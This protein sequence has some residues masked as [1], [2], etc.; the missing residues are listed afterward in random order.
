[1]FKFCRALI[2]ASLLFL[3][4]CASQKEVAEPRKYIEPR[5]TDEKP[6]ELLVNKVDIE[7]EFS[8]T[9]TKPYVEHLFPVSLERA[10]RVWATDRLKAVDYGASRTAKFIIKDASVTEQVEKSPDI[11]Q[12]DRLKYHAS[13]SVILK[14]IDQNGSMAQTSIDAWRELGIPADTSI[15]QKEKYWFEMIE[16]LMTDFDA[17]IEQDAQQY[18]NMYI[19]DSKSILEY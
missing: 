17:K 5:F 3:T 9:F 6:I 4:A 18:L 14:V 15:D 10:A 7:S 19:K 16:Q 11:F 1:M 13:L 12:K 8:P 2:G